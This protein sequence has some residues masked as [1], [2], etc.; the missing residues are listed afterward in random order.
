MNSGTYAF[1]DT[2]FF[3]HFP[4]IDSVD[5]CNHLSA[6]QVTLVVDQ[7]VLRELDEIKDGARGQSRRDKARSVVPK[8]HKMLDSNHPQLV[9]D[10]VFIVTLNAV[11][12]DFV[13][14]RMN[15]VVQDDLIVAGMM[16]FRKDHPDARIVLVANDGGIRIRARMKKFDTWDPGESL[17]RIDI[18]SDEDKELISLRRQVAESQNKKP[19]FDFGLNGADGIQKFASFAFPSFPRDQDSEEVIELNLQNERNACL[20]GVGVV[21]PFISQNMVNDYVEKVGEY[22]AKFEEWLKFLLLLRSCYHVQFSFV[23]LN[24]GATTRHVEVEV[25]VPDTAVLARVKEIDVVLDPL[26]KP[27]RPKQPSPRDMFGG[28]PYLNP[29]LFESFNQNYQRRN[30]ADFESTDVEEDVVKYG[31]FLCAF[32]REKRLRRPL[33]VHS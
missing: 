24:T 32:R 8:L 23:L 4:P 13:K 26:N 15:P 18:S 11:D 25:R 9:R 33:R 7:Q 14:E 19:K 12:I 21:H 20:S 17:E 31:R 30:P 22:L 3:M 6:H 28:T 5:W 2:N 29:A 27:R 16:T 10:N 1:L